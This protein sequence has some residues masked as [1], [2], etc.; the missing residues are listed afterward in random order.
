VLLTVA[1][2]EP[3]TNWAPVPAGLSLLTAVGR[4]CE[5]PWESLQP[6]LTLVIRLEFAEC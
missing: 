4:S 1:E 5:A 2:A 6:G 3:K